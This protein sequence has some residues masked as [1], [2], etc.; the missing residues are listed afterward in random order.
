MRL[1]A[2]YLR[3]A[4]STRPLQAGKLSVTVRLV[5]DLQKKAEHATPITGK[6]PV[7]PTTARVDV[8]TQVETG[9]AAPK[10]ATYS[11][12]NGTV[13]ARQAQHISDGKSGPPPT[14][15]GGVLGFMLN[16][17][18]AIPA[19]VDP[20]KATLK[21]LTAHVGQEIVVTT[22]DKEG[23]ASLK[24]AARKGD[25]ADT[26]AFLLGIT[27]EGLVLADDVKG[28]NKRVLQTEFWAVA[29]VSVGDAAVLQDP[30]W[31]STYS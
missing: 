6:S 10:A 21:D 28:K 4:M 31:A 20:T 23:F 8:K 25:V 17:A 30:A 26:K 29:R 3:S 5:A 12:A 18:G 7:G 2:C 22:W 15:G 24:E 11:G 19:A 14:R 27:P 16:Q 13:S 9:G 1:S